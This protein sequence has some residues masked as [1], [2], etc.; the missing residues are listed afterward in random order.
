MKTFVPDYY[1]EFKCIAEKCRHSCCVGW[2]IDIDEESL[3]RFKQAD[4]EIGRRLREDI[5]EG[6]DGACFRLKEGDR[7]PFLNEKGLCDLIIELG[8]ES[9]CQICADHPRFRSFFS[10]RTELG[11]GL[12]CEEAARILLQ[13]QEKARL[14]LWEDDGAQEQCDEEEEALLALRGRLVEIMQ[15]R[16]LC[17]EQRV[18]KMLA[19]AGAVWPEAPLSQWAQFLLELERLDEGWTRRLEALCADGASPQAALPETPF[20]QLMV[21]F[22]LRHLPGALE[23]GDVRGRVLLCALLWNTVRALAAAE[24]ADMEGLADIARMCSSEIEYSDENIQAI[25]E[26]ME[27]FS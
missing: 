1:P 18:E 23:D 13:R 26:K 12:C 24:N 22:L 11:L 17:V 14:I 20:E 5:L 8:E 2:E 6:E 3:R 16:S 4:G 25:L 19:E 10:D 7:C 15:E 27:R 9:L 21:Y